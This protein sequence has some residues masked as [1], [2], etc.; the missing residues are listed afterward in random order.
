M[1]QEFWNQIVQELNSQDANV[2]H[3]AV[4]N[5]RKKLLPPNPPLAD[6]VKSGIIPKLVDLLAHSRFVWNITSHH[7]FHL[8]TPTIP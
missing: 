8:S 4:V 5:V 3:Q 6:A 2:M 1:D 7:A